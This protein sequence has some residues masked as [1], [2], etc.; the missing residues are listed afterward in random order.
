MLSAQL[1]S[2]LQLAVDEIDGGHRR[3]GDA[4]VLHGEMA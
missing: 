1:A 4:R 3:P 2:Q